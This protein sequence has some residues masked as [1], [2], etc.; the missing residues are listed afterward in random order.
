MIVYNI[1]VK[2]NWSIAE[3]WLAWQKQEQ[4]PG[5]MATGLFDDYTMY[6]L[7]EQDDMEGPSFTIQYFTSSSERYRQY[8]DQFAAAFMEKAFAR[9]ADGF[10]AF[11][12]VME[13]V[14]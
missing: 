3:K 13:A 6:R 14:N 7:L 2:V 11:S 12:T 9:W 4:I 10:I 1:T 5:I 8:I